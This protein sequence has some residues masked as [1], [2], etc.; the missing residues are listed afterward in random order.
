MGRG[1][2]GRRRGVVRQCLRKKERK[3]AKVRKSKQ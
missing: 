2:R 3:K 1:R